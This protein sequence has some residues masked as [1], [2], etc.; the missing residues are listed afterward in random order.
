MNL[1]LDKK[2]VLDRGRCPMYNPAPCVGSEFPMCMSMGK[3]PGKRIDKD[4]KP[5]KVEPLSVRGS[6]L[7][8]SKVR[9][10]WSGDLEG[11]S[12]FKAGSVQLVLD[13][14]DGPRHYLV[15]GL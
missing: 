15:E 3:D 11:G 8:E 1:V 6:G 5:V 2:E 14:L 9:W 4:T 7:A 12:Y 13:N 10:V